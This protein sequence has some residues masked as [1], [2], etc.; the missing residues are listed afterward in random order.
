MVESA[1]RCRKLMQV[2]T[3]LEYPASASMLGRRI[4]TY[5]ITREIGRGGMGVVYEAIHESIGQR[6]AIKVLHA[7]FSKEPKY[8]QRS[9]DEARAVS[10]VQHAGLVKIF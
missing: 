8:V 3:T 5:R 4:G 6:A 7:E 10:M 9:L 2:E 1:W